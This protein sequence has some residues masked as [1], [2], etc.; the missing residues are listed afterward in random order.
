M[1]KTNVRPPWREGGSFRQRRVDGGLGVR[2]KIKLDGNAGVNVDAV[3]HARQRLLARR[4]P[5]A[6]V[7]D[8]AGEHERKT[9]GAVR[10]FVP[11]RLVGQRRIGMIDARQRL[12]G[13]RARV[14][15]DGPRIGPA[16]GE[17][18][19]G[20]AVIGGADKPL[21]RRP[22]EHDVDQ[23][24]PL[25]ARRRGK[26]GGQRQGFFRVGHRLKMPRMAARANRSGERDFSDVVADTG[27]LVKALHDR[28]A[29][30]SRAFT[31]DGS[32]PRIAQRSRSRRR[33]PARP[34]GKLEELR[35]PAA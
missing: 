6:V 34:R 26:I 8:R 22:L 15:R 17:R 16:R 35:A 27:P 21:E 14:R 13:C 9:A 7:A 18:L 5:E 30:F 2:R 1:S 23:L 10:E 11:R 29:Y 32:G 33:G 12:P 19:D 20:E 24:A 31:E 4:K 28:G 25:I 3:K